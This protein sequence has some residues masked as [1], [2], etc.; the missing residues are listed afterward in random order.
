MNSSM[1][2]K[3]SLFQRVV[4]LLIKPADFFNEVKHS[5][6]EREP[7]VWL[8]V[9]VAGYSLFSLILSYFVLSTFNGSGLGI[10]SDVME[11]AVNQKWAEVLIDI[12]VTVLYLLLTILLMPLWHWLVQKVGVKAPKYQ[13]VKALLYPAVPLYLLGWIPLV[14]LI[15]FAVCIYAYYKAFKILLEMNTWQIVLFSIMTLVAGIA[16]LLVLSTFVV[17]FF[18]TTGLLV[19]PGLD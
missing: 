12:V 1:S 8:L 17:L 16:M 6:D 15:G 9:S 11:S 4:S 18:S 13:T 10:P 2:K 19:I 7:I 3:G 14:S 5:S